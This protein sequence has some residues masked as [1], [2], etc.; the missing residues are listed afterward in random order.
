MRSGLTVH[1]DQRR[2]RYDMA[3]LG[4]LQFGNLSTLQIQQAL[5]GTLPR[6]QLALDRLRDQ[7]LVVAGWDDGP[8]P[9]V[10][11][12]RLFFENLERSPR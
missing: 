2:R 4:L 12:Y 9:R 10:R 7:S 5:G 1:L 11:R 6:I 3:I 8:S